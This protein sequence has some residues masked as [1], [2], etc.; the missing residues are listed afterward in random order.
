MPELASAGP[1]PTTTGERLPWSRR[2]VRE[3]RHVTDMTPHHVPV[4]VGGKPAFVLVS[5]GI[6]LQ[7]PTRAVPHAMHASSKPG[8]KAAHKTLV[9]ATVPPNCSMCSG[10][11][12]TP[13]TWELPDQALIRT[14]DRARV[15]YVTF[16]SPWRLCDRHMV[17]LID[18][19]YSQGMLPRPD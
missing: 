4:T 8:R 14:G 10:I 17:E 11:T 15:K 3:V 2:V 6:P 19:R 1:G 7:P 5:G 18:T 13:A 12:Y 16:D 9:A